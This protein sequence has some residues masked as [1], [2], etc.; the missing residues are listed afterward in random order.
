[1]NSKPI[2]NI[3][4]ICGLSLCNYDCAYCASGQPGQPRSRTN[5]R[6]WISNK[7]LDAFH[8]TLEW[9]SRQ[10]FKIGLRLQTVGE[11]MVSAEFLKGAAK[12][13]HSPNIQFVELVSNGSLLKS[14]I[15]KLI[16]EYGANPDKLLLWITY[17]HTE[18]TAQELLD[19]VCFARDMGIR[20]NVNA[21]IFPNNTK[22]L[23]EIHTLCKNNDIDL[24]IDV[25]HNFNQ[26]YPNAPFIAALDNDGA[27]VLKHLEPDIQILRTAI[28]AASAPRGWQCSA[29]YDYIH[30]TPEG[31]IYPCRTSFFRK[32]R[33][34]YLGSALD[35]NYKLQTR[36]VE[37]KHCDIGKACICKEDYLHMRIARS[38]QR[39]S[40]SMGL[41]Y[42]G[43]VSPIEE[44]SMRQLI[45]RANNM[46]LVQVLR[47][48]EHR[49]L[50]TA[51]KQANPE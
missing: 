32:G 27:E 43:N 16:N 30:I 41:G 2:I 3:W 7:Y 28:I 31:A 9:I 50:R 19:Q 8:K 5:D 29:G 24:C 11:P 23:L 51:T 4:Y 10:N 33:E 1:M 37:Y 6:E 26:S 18:T 35:D 13:T 49:L 42:Q 40:Q 25:G 39:K 14:R 15:P 21:L 47:D 38:S 12:I 45:A 44:Q 46:K 34:A 17:H 22:N 48:I 36:N 20:V